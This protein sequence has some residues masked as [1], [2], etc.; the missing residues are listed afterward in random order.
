ME[1]CLKMIQLPAA[2]G[3]TLAVTNHILY[4]KEVSTANIKDEVESHIQNYLQ[5]NDPRMALQPKIQS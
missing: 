1:V 2:W 5:M 4:T 3:F